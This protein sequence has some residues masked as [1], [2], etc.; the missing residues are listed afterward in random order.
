[1]MFNILELWSLNV[2]NVP[3]RQSE[4]PLKISKSYPRQLV[5][6]SQLR[7]SRILNFKRGQIGVT[8]SPWIS[9]IEPSLRKEQDTIRRSSQFTRDIGNL[10]NI[11]NSLIFKP[12]LR[13]EQNTI[14]RSNQW[15]EIL[16]TY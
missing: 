7:K 9:N 16:V 11:F 10:L 13:K 8:V 14:M 4:M 5:L 15:P 1:M 6:L 2:S 12:S 3:L